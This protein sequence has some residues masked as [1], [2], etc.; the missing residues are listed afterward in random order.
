MNNILDSAKMIEFIDKL[1]DLTNKNKLDW[2]EQELNYGLGR[3]VSFGNMSSYLTKYDQYN[4][5]ITHNSDKDLYQLGLR[6]QQMNILN[7]FPN[8]INTSNLLDA[9]KN[10]NKKSLNDFVDKILEL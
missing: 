4:L 8:T 7:S 2:K 5:V 6:D 9:I 1:I 3:G 10:Q